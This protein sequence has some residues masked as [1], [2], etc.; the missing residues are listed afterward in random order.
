[1]KRSNMDQGNDNTIQGQ[2]PTVVLEKS[3]INAPNRL[4]LVLIIE[5]ASLLQT[6]ITDCESAVASAWIP[7]KQKQTFLYA[8]RACT[9]LTYSLV[10]GPAYS[11]A[12]FKKI[13]RVKTIKKSAEVGRSSP[14]PASQP[15]FDSTSTRRA[16][17]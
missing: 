9:F 11:G 16:S 3:V 15:P 10:L 5:W 7:K 6:L 17:I 12:R 14:V 4:L 8:G 1:M 13:C 2:F